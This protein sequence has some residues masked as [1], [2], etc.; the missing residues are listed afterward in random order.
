MQAEYS[1][2]LIGWDGANAVP[3]GAASLSAEEAPQNP[4]LKGFV[5]ELLEAVQ[6]GGQVL[7]VLPLG[8]Q[9]EAAV[10]VA[11]PTGEVRDGPVI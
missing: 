4:A 8:R 6:D 7:G 11:V 9:G 10:L 3:D 5:A 2:Q 1:F